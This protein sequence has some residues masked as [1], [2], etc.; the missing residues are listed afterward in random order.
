MSFVSSKGNILC[1]LIKIELSKILTIINRVIKGLHCNCTC[2][3]SLEIYMFL[4][5]NA[6]SKMCLISE[7]IG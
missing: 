3:I 5:C 4:A 7:E 1:R 6:T 2:H